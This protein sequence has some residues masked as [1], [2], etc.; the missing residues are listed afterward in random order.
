VTWQ[1]EL[2]QLDVELA[3]GRITA[4]EYRTRRD[5]VTAAAANPSSG[6]GKTD[7]P[8]TPAPAP[9]PAT[10]PPPAAESTQMIAPVTGSQPR[11]PRG[12]PAPGGEADRTQAVNPAWGGDNADADRTQAVPR[13][14]IPPRAPG[15][16]SPAGGFPQPQYQQ[17]WQGEEQLP[18]QWSGPELPSSAP[19]ATGFDSGFEQSD[20]WGAKQGPEVFEESGGNTTKIIAIVAAIVLLA[21]LGVGAYFLWGRDSGGTPPAAQTNTPAAPTTTKPKNP[22]GI[23]ELPGKQDVSPVATFAEVQELNYLTPEEASAYQDAQPAK[24]GLVVGQLQGGGRAI[25]LVV[26]V[27]SAAAAKNAVQSLVDLQLT[28]KATKAEDAPDNVQVTATV[29]TIRAH[30]ASGDTIVR[31]EVSGS[32]A[33]NASDFEKVVQ[34]QLSSLPADD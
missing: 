30:Y 2:R 31:I 19:W 8:A 32:G 33:K 15:P 22:M 26:Q 7:A 1:D 13:S 28:F 16:A 4:D 21:G 23:A 20:P 12:G 6:G 17:G 24:V 18:P 9:Q 27:G 5:R 34:S 14:N 3:S 11:P 29:D 25:V 10:P